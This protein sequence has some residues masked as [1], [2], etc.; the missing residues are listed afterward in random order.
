M[1][2]GQKE[3]VAGSMVRLMLA[4][5]KYKD[6]LTDLMELEVKRLGTEQEA[7]LFR[8]NSIGSKSIESFL[9]L[10]TVSIPMFQNHI[11][12]QG[13]TQPG[14]HRPSRSDPQIKKKTVLVLVRLQVLKICLARTDRFWLVNP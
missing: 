14:I 3:R 10:G 7:L 8:E 5:G 13:L 6:Y 1:S 12:G 9:K 4:T 2:A 11:L